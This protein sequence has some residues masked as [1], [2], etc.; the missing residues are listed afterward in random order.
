VKYLALIWGDE[1]GW[2]GLS[3]ADKQAVYARYR[4][5]SEAAGSKLVD[6]AE[7]APS[8]SAT[9]IRVRDGETHVSDGPYAETKEQ[10]GGFFVFEC[11]S[12]DE[13]VALAKEIPMSREGAVEVRPEYVGAAA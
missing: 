9:T 1:S 11:D 12:I 3:E 6:G 8:Q 2:E 13:A 5:F 4:A 7:T 10:L